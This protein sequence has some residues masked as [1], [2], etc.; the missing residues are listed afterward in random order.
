MYNQLQDPPP[1]LFSHLSSCHHSSRYFFEAS[2][3]LVSWLYH[4]L[5]FD[6]IFFGQWLA[7][8]EVHPGK[9][10]RRRYPN[11][12]QSPCTLWWCLWWLLQALLMFSCNFEGAYST[13]LQA[14]TATPC[15]F[16]IISFVIQGRLQ[17]SSTCYITQHVSLL[18][19]CIGVFTLFNIYLRMIIFTLVVDRINL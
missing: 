2:P 12:K 4:S 6:H 16:F 3:M 1:H 7:A 11:Q 17:K 9:P 15:S 18:V 14:L 19:L 10:Y 5:T 13:F 8:F